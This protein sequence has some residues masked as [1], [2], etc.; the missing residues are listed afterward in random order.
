MDLTVASARHGSTSTISAQGEIDLS[1]ADKLRAELDT[2]L[3]SDSRQVIVDLSAVTFLDSTGIGV[4]AGAL[5]SRGDRKVGIVVSP[6]PVEKVLLLTG[7]DR[8]F[9][10]YSSIDDALGDLTTPSA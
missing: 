7:M 2:V 6:G 9:P 4:L 10:L 3:A 8:V 5:R 1:S